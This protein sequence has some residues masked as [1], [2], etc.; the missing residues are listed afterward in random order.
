LAKKAEK[1][2]LENIVRSSRVG[3]ERADVPRK[4]DGY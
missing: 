4:T 2:P 1:L 3:A